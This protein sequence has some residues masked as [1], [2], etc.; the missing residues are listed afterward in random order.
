[1]EPFKGDDCFL[2]GQVHNPL[3]Y[4][5]MNLDQFVRSS[6]S[7]VHVIRT[8]LNDF[9]KRHLT[10]DSLEEKNYK[11]AGLGKKVLTK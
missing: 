4:K 10:H 1:M 8:N 6:G 7:W 5:G 9:E 3:A 2:K 11:L